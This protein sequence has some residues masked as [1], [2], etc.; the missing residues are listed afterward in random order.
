MPLSTV[1]GYNDRVGV[2]K[3][4]DAVCTA[5]ISSEKQ[6]TTAY[7]CLEKAPGE[8]HDIEK[9]SFQLGTGEQVELNGIVDLW[10]RKDFARISLKNAYPRFLKSG[11]KSGDT[12]KLVA[13]DLE[14]AQLD[15][16]DNC[17]VD[18]DISSA[19]VFSYSCQSKGHYSG[20]PIMEG[21]IVVGIHLGYKPKIDRRVGL[22]FSLLTDEKSDILEIEYVKE[23]CHTRASVGLGHTRMHV[24]GCD[25]ISPILDAFE[26]LT[27][28]KSQVRTDVQ[29]TALI[30]AAKKAEYDAI[31][32][33]IEAAT[34][35]VDQCMA[36]AKAENN[37]DK[38]RECLSTFESTMN[39]IL[40]DIMVLS[41]AIEKDYKEQVK[42]EIRAGAGAQIGKVA[43][44]EQ[45]WNEYT[46]CM[47]ST[48]SL[49]DVKERSPAIKSCR[50]QM[51]SKIWTV[52]KI[53]SGP[54][55]GPCDSIWRPGTRPSLCT[56]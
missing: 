7:H 17:L 23:G 48:Q 3:A 18:Q 53:P 25:P 21:E 9:I 30:V 47:S 31:I 8:I 38:A 43:A 50:D 26:E 1:E 24:R 41:E 36:E 32:G 12:L 49:P 11:V 22:D 45:A 35:S 13:Y 6:I 40:S 29:N 15:I 56:M 27:S 52:I 14:T 44:V 34:A 42:A 2:L 5:F 55:A 16:Q 46:T 20:A 19:G 10:P 28:R 54:S 4:G 39:T 37:A 33:R 51:R